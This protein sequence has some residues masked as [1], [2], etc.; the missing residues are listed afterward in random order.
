MSDSD[1]EYVDKSM[2]SLYLNPIELFAYCI[3]N[4]F[5]KDDWAEGFFLPIFRD[6]ENHIIKKYDNGEYPEIEKLLKNMENLA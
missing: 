5:I 3:N 6:R 4:G 2:D 1:Q